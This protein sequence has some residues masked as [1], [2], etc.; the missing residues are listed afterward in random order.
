[1]SRAEI[2]I[3]D[4]LASGD[5]PSVN[6]AIQGRLDRLLEEAAELQRAVY[7]AQPVSAKTQ[8]PRSAA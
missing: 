2:L 8:A 7:A 5:D 3:K 6:A 4:V 1:M